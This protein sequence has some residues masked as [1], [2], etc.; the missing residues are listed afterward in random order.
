MLEDVLKDARSN[1]K[2]KQE[3]VA[4]AI[5]VTKQ[6]YLKWENGTTEPKASQIAALAKVLDITP[7]E[8]CGGYL[9]KRYTLDK[10]ITEVYKSGVTPEMETLKV[11]NFIANHEGFIHEL[12]NL[13]QTDLDDEKSTYEQRKNING[14][15]PEEL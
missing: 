10:F 5:N 3:D 6:T 11:W 9:Y 12:N 13:D 8:I 4:N 15:N 7:N 1:K 2:L 14:V